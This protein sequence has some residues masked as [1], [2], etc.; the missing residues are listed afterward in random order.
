MI[1]S[2][3]LQGS[4]LNIASREDADQIFINSL[5]FIAEGHCEAGV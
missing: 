1:L 2:V 3:R 4:C 5:D